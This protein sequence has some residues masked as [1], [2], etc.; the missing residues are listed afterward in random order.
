MNEY[1]KKYRFDE[2]PVH[3]CHY[4][5]DRHYKLSDSIKYLQ[6]NREYLGMDK[7]VLLCFTEDSMQ[8]DP[9]ENIRGLYFKEFLGDSIYTF[10]GLHHYLDE[11]DTKEY[12]LKQIEF[13][14]NAGF[15][16]I[17]IM[18]EGKAACRKYFNH[19]LD[20]ERFEGFFA[21]AE[22]KQFPLLIHA[23]DV[24]DSEEMRRGCDTVHAEILNV[25]KKHPKLCITFA[26]MMFLSDN[27]DKLTEI[28]ETYPNVS[29]DLALGGFMKDISNNIEIWREFF[30]KY[31]H[32]IL[33]GTDNYNNFITNDD[34]FELIVRN[35][36]IRKL[37]E[38]K[39]PFST[40]VYGAK[41][42][43]N[44]LLISKESVDNIY[45]N[46][47]TRLYGE[48][49]RKVNYN[50]AQEYTTKLI[51]AFKEDKLKVFAKIELPD[52]IYPEEQ[53]NLHKGNTFAI[54]TL[55]EIKSYYENKVSE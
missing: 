36:P 48:T 51:E 47:F 21:F 54:E 11:R 37:L 20:D 55:E 33:F 46:N 43:F 9:Y 53:K 42:V 35:E 26:H 40:R 23:G 2:T 45:R 41:A 8:V 39:E 50:L 27:I 25:L 12:Y 3:D 32:R 31:S 14:Y 29:F 17:K 16:G 15:D 24:P 7:I 34:C 49:P 44:P 6:M 13:F 30:T 4:H 52:W 19:K 22:E 1:L 18:G 10:A 5:V 28:F 38:Y